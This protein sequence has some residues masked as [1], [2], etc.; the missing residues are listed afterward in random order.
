MVN[1]ASSISIQSNQIPSIAIYIPSSTAFLSLHFAAFPPPFRTLSAYCMDMRRLSRPPPSPAPSTCD[2]MYNRQCP[3]LYY[4]TVRWPETEMLFD[5]P[6]LQLSLNRRAALT[7][8]SN[9]TQSAHGKR[10]GGAI[11]PMA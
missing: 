1:P 3:P 5:P 11:M 10:G 9:W 7:S 6:P 8:N 2:F 4:S